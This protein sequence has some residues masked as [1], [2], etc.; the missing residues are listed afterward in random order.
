VPDVEDEFSVTNNVNRLLYK[1]KRQSHR[2]TILGKDKFEY[3]VILKSE[4][5]SNIISLTLEG[6]EQFNFYKQPFVGDDPFLYGSYAVYLKERIAGQ[7]TG[8]LCHIHRPEIIDAAGNRC[9]GDMFIDGNKLYI[10]IPQQWLCNARYPVLVDPVVGTQSVGK[11]K[12]FFELELVTNCYHILSA[13]NGLCTAFVYAADDDEGCRPV[14]YSDSADGPK[15]RLTMQEQFISGTVNTTKPKGWRSGTFQT[16]ATIP[17][18]SWVWFGIYTDLSFRPAYDYDGECWHYSFEDFMD[19]GIPNVI[20]PDYLYEDDYG[21]V[22]SMYFEYSLNQNHI[23]TITQGVTLTDSRKLQRGFRRLLLSQAHINSVLQK[24]GYYKRN[25]LASGNNSTA[26]THSSDY[27]RQLKMNC[28]ASCIANIARIFIALIYDTLHIADIVS[29]G[30]NFIAKINDTITAV[31][32]LLGAGN[33]FNYFRELYEQTHA[34]AEIKN[35]THFVRNTVDGVL[36]GASFIRRMS[37]SILV[38]TVCGI[39]DYI[40]GRFLKSK[41]E[42]VLHSRVTR[43]IILDSRIKS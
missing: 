16:R 17:A 38:S 33:S 35:S 18:D 5:A 42:I 22:L 11:Y 29:I 37:I 15:N 25:L 40:T 27:K 3:D 28:N 13:I 12:R 10:K 19:D 43:E 23:R 34:D 24:T 20:D 41:G 32:A 9:W 4:P 26:L 8:K 1:G 31:C 2:W 14:I 21:R 6:A 7:G 30:R 39:R 36:C